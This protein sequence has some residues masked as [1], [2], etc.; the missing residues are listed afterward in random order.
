MDKVL[1]VG[2][3]VHRQVRLAAAMRD[4]TM[5]EFTEHA[6]TEYL[7]RYEK[8]MYAEVMAAS[9]AQSMEHALVDTRE[10]Y[11]TKEENDA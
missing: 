7:G 6:I 5:S 3:T 11:T 10:T 4:M 8:Q 2:E 9:K 1:R